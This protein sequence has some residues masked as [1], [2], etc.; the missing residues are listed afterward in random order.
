MK[1]S[2]ILN[3]LLVV[4]LFFPWI[5]TIDPSTYAINSLRGIEYLVHSA[6]FLLIGSLYILAFLLYS[7]VD[8]KVTL[9]GYIGITTIFLFFCLYM[10][11]TQ[12]IGVSVL[13]LHGLLAATIILVVSDIWLL[14]ESNKVT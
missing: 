14:F 13:K 8:S 12:Y 2:L 10:V 4:T 6:V 9:V 1:K 7:F 5:N 3:I 11:V